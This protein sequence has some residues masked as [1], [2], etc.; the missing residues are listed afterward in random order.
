MEKIYITA[1]EL[2]EL[3]G[4][5]HK[6]SILPTFQCTDMKVD[7]YTRNG[8]RMKVFYMTREEF[9]NYN[10]QKIINASKVLFDVNKFEKELKEIE[11]RG[12]RV[13]LEKELKSLND[14]QL[15]TDQEGPGEYQLQTEEDIYIDYVV[16]EDYDIIITGLKL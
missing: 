14:N 12:L 8:R 6:I 1:N 4:D 5:Y 3:E 13:H 16:D 2:K 15:S 11:K 7:C 10:N 9:K